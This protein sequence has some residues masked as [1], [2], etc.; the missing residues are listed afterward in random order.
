[1]VSGDYR[2]FAYRIPWRGPTRRNRHIQTRSSSIMCNPPSMTP[3]D[4]TQAWSGSVKTQELPADSGVDELAARSG[5]LFRACGLRPTSTGL[6]PC[7]RVGYSPLKLS[8]SLKWPLV[9]LTR[10]SAKS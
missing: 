4:A 2:L 3:T 9:L 10:Q 1:M 7:P 5:E 8:Y 6:T